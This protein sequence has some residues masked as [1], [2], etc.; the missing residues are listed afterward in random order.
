MIQDM[1][2]AIGGCGD[3]MKRHFGISVMAVMVIQ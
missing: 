1:E 2:Y 3:P